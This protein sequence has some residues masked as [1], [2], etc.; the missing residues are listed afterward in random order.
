MH[1][2]SNDVMF[3]YPFKF[4]RIYEVKTSKIITLRT[5]DILLLLIS[6][7][8]VKAECRPCALQCNQGQCCFLKDHTGDGRRPFSQF[9]SAIEESLLQGK[10][11]SIRNS[12]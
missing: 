2:D 3:N 1:S 7:M 6:S 9:L 10:Q 4:R 5:K 12:D 8:Y 11:K